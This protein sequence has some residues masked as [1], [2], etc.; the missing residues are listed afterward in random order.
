MS[1]RADHE[2]KTI[3]KSLKLSSDDLSIIEQKSREKGMNFS[4]YMIESAVHGETGLTPEIL[5]RIE[6]IIER[7]ARIANENQAGDM[8]LIRMEVDALWEYLK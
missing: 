4:R 1:K 7:C 3:T 5:C 2:K 6:N 8:E